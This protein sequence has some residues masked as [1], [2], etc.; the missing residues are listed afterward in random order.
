MTFRIG[1]LGNHLERKLKEVIG[2][3]SSKEESNTEER[4]EEEE[5]QGG[6]TISHKKCALISETSQSHLIRKFSF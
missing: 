3:E 2:D 6:I 5:I 1:V 4:A